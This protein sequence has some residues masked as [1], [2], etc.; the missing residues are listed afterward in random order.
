MPIFADLNFGLMALMMA[1]ALFV[2]MLAVLEIGRRLGLRDLAKYGK[3]GLTS[4]GKADAPVYALLAL[5]IGFTF[6]GAAS[7][8]DHR[9]ELIGRQVNALGTAWVRI[10]MLPDSL[11][12]GV[13]TM[14]RGYV[15]ALWRMYGDSVTNDAF[16]QPP[17]LE[18]A[19]HELWK[20]AAA[21]SLTPEGEKARMLLLPSLNDAFDAVESE[22]LARRIHPPVLIYAMLGIAALAAS[23]FAGVALSK[24]PRNSLFY[25]MCI[26]A[27]I[28]S[29]LF[30]TIEL[31][32]PRRGIVRVDEMARQELLAVMK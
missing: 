29:A 26:A 22:R 6:N 9:R 17:Q 32:Y 4:V 21:L 18:A 24:A 8:F 1:L 30:V 16:A 13:R 5:L 31:E 23:L 27:T 20:R 10:D 19:R 12:P 15:D 3:D 14:F 11:Q 7:R 25:M 2:A 28:A